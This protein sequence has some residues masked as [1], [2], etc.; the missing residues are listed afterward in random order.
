MTL[1]DNPHWIFIY[2]KFLKQIINKQRNQNSTEA[3]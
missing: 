1:Y 2:I 3:D